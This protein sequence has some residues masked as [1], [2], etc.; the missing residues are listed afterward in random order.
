MVEV[1]AAPSG[2]SLLHLIDL[3]YAERAD[4]GFGSVTVEVSRPAV[5]VPTFAS[6]C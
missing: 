5:G 1:T 4:A 3:R 2:G 6:R